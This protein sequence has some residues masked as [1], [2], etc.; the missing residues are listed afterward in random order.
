MTASLPKGLSQAIAAQ[1]R[2]EFRRWRILAVMAG[3]CLLGL[4]L[5]IATGPA[6]LSPAEVLR[7]LLRPEEVAPMTRII[8]Q[9][10]RLPMAL[11]ALV[12]GAALGVGGAEIQTLLN[13]PMASPYTLGL[14]RAGLGA[15]LVIAYGSFGLPLPLAVPIGAFLFTMLAAS[16]LFGLASLRRV[17]SSMLVLAGIALLFLFQSFLSLVQFLSAPEISQQI[18]F[19]LFGSLTKSSWTTLAVT[20]VVTAVCVVLLFRDS[21]RL[22]A[23]KLGETRAASLGVDVA[24]LRFRTLVLVAVM[25]ATAI[26]FVGII[27]FVGLVA[28]HVARMLVGEDQRFFLPAAMI[29]GAAFLSGASVLSKVILPGALFPVGIVTSFVGVPFFFWILLRAK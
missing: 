1:R 18:M 14:S 11:M 21:W 29:A 23:L 25:T 7:A 2:S 4:I 27:G 9:D 20:T 13:N 12:A 17:S 10:L 24:A 8:V 26:S 3:L 15:S 6:L 22:T 19:W 28:P 5:D 16:I